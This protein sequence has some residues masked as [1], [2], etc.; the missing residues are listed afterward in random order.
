[1]APWAAVAKDAGITSRE[2]IAHAAGEEKIL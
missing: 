2:V 1:M